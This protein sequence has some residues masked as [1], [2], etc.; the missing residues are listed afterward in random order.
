MLLKGGIFCQFLFLILGIVEVNDSTNEKVWS[1]V[2]A[3]CQWVAVAENTVVMVT[4]ENID[5]VLDDVFGVGKLFVDG[6]SP[7]IG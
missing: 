1:N 2:V 5:V 3:F 4:I 6:V 7:N